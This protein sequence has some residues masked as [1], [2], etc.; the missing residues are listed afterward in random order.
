MHSELKKDLVSVMIP[1]Y[2]GEKTLPRCL[3]SLLSQS[4]KK[5]EIILVNDGSYDRTAKIAKEY[6]SKFEADG[7]RFIYREQEN[8]GLGG[9]INTALKSFTGEYLCWGDVDDFWYPES[10]R[11]R[12]QFLEKHNEYGSVSSDAHIY[13][14]E[15]LKSPI[16][17]VSASARNLEDENQF[18][19]HLKGQPLYCPGCHMVRSA[20]F[21]EANPEKQIYPA[22]YAQNNQLLMPIY[23]KYKH[24][25]IG[26]PLYGYIVSSNSMSHKALSKK[27]EKARIIEY[28][29]AIKYSII[30]IQMP[31]PEKK[32][33]LRINERKRYDSLIDF[34]VKRHDNLS[35]IYYYIIRKILIRYYND[36]EI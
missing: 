14:E 34:S 2:N 35:K 18:L 33:Y 8:K 24:K 10:I 16:G 3:D 5:L 27:E 17:L 30:K 6:K 7:R 15:D 25:Y 21:L 13:N 4:Y 1:C 31:E 12:K 11:L 29:D 36:L 9:A 20:A 23:Y 22:R 32:K 26:I 19:N 28:Y